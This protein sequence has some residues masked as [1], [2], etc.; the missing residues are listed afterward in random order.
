MPAAGAPDH[1]NDITP[2]TNGNLLQ[3]LDCHSNNLRTSGHPYRSPKQD[4]P[5]YQ[6][7]DAASHAGQHAGMTCKRLLSLLVAILRSSRSAVQSQTDLLLEN[8]ALRHQVAVLRKDNPRPSLAWSDRIFWGWLHR[9]W[10]KW[11]RCLVIVKPETVI[12]WHRH[13]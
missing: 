7:F 11:S 8:M 3:F 5:S 13:G 6:R 10:S 1:L 4:L 2:Y 12:G 9:V